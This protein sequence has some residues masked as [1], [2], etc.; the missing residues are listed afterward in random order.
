MQD[1]K[2]FNSTNGSKRKTQELIQKKKIPGQSMWDLWCTK[3]HWDRVFPRVL[4]FSPVNFIPPVLHY[5][6]K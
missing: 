6:E 4:W 1:K 3:W 5:L 2:E